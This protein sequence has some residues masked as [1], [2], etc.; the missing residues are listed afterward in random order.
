MVDAGSVASQELL[1]VA[2]LELGRPFGPVQLGDASRSSTDAT[3]TSPKPGM[4]VLWRRVMADASNGPAR[5]RMRSTFWGGRA[6][7]DRRHREVTEVDG[8]GDGVAGP[9][10]VSEAPNPAASM[11]RTTSTSWLA[12]RTP[13]TDAATEPVTNHRIPN[14]SMASSTSRMAPTVARRPSARRSDGVHV[15]VV[16]ELGSEQVRW[17]HKAHAGFAFQAG[18]EARAG[19][20]QE[21]LVRCHERCPVHRDE[22]RPD[23]PA[24]GT[25]GSTSLSRRRRPGPGRPR[26]HRCHRRRATGARPP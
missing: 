22:G 10:G 8:L 18:I 19:E 4:S 14:R 21:L 17:S 25:G 24:S 1:A 16:V 6:V 23:P 2:Q 11:S 26:R 20:Q 12:R 7:D 13:Y 15:G 5:R 3:H 9:E